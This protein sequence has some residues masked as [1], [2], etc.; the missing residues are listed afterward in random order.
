MNKFNSHRIQENYWRKQKNDRTKNVVVI[1]DYNGVPVGVFVLQT[2]GIVQEF[3][4]NN[5]SILLTSF[6]VNHNKQI[7]GCYKIIGFITRL[8]K[9]LLS[10]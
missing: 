7:K 2:G 1:L 4:D 10:N 5:D 6:S 3:T 8:C 9:I